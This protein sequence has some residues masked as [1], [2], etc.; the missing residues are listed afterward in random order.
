MILFWWNSLGM[1]GEK[2]PREFPVMIVMHNWDRL[3]VLP[4][5]LWA[6]NQEVFGGVHLQAFILLR[7]SLSAS[8]LSTR[9]SLEVNVC[10]PGQPFLTLIQL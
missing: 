4:V 3:I 7:S 1:G 9:K 10:V 8:G 5:C 2:T 6:V